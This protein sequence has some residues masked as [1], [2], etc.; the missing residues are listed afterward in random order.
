MA[1]RTK[2]IVVLIDGLSADYLA[3]HRAR[4]PHLADMAEQG[5]AVDRLRSVVPATSRPGRASIITGVAAD[6]HGIYGNQILDGANGNGVRFRSARAEDLRAPSLA[7]L[8]TQAGLD[9]ACIGFGLVAPEDARIFVPPWWEHETLRAHP[10]AKAPLPGDLDV[11]RVLK[12][13]DGRLAARRPGRV[14]LAPPESDHGGLHPQ[15]AGSAADH[16]MIDLAAE[17]A[18][19][20]AA[21]DLIL[22]EIAVTDLIQ[23]Y[24]GYESE[25]AHWALATAD[26]LIGSLVYRLERAGRLED[27]MIAAVSDHGHTPIATA[28]YP[29]RVIGDMVFSLEGASMNVAVR[30]AAE[31]AAVERKL[32]ELGVTPLDGTHL[33]P[34]LRDTIATFTA[35]DTMAFEMVAKNAVREGVTGAPLTISTH[36]LRPGTPADDRACI[37]YGGGIAPGRQE[38]AAA[39]QFAPTVAAAL[40]LDLA[41]FPAEALG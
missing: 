20:D 11:V 31:R 14:S 30:D 15:I 40:G 39:E 19:S 10:S 34:A 29:E 12:D 41:P 7:R 22:T 3:T 25:A 9:V 13:E 35:P 37:F 16:L 24:H 27:T 32:A 36:G 33:P 6:R 18:C 17:L 38:T 21:P 1:T 8:A 28:I 2:A 5:F 4:L 23:H 26:R